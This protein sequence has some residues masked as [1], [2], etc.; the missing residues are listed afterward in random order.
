MKILSLAFLLVAGL[1]LAGSESEYFL[2]NIIGLVMLFIAGNK[3]TEEDNI[4]T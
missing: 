2:G 4:A 3:L 1:L